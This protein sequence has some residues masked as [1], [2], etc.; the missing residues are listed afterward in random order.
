MRPMLIRQQLPKLTDQPSAGD[1]DV[2]SEIYDHIM[3]G[4]SRDEVRRVFAGTEVYVSSRPRLSESQK[5]AIAE[6]LQR[7]AVAVVAKR[8]RITERHC[9]RLKSLAQPRSGG[10]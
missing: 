3:A 6:E 4:S 8:W 9:R 10:L 5:A 7:D 1:A 2:I